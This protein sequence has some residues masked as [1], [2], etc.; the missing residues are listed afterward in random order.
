METHPNQP[1]IVA[2]IAVFTNIIS[3]WFPSL[4]GQVKG[5]LRHPCFG[6]SG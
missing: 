6:G 3:H 2:N 5:R 4:S 1:N